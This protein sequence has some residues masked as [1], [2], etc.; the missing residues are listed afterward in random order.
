MPYLVKEGPGVPKLMDNRFQCIFGSFWSKDWSR[1]SGSALKSGP[2]AWAG[3]FSRLS[4]GVISRFFDFFGQKIGPEG[5][6]GL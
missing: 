1:G 6:G 2:R 3:G 4:Q 5:P